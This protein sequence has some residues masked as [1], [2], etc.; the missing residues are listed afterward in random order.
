M[1][2]ALGS[3]TCLVHNVANLKTALKIEDFVKTYAFKELH[4]S[5]PVS[6]AY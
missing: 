1:E 6:I 4:S 2:Q 5:L 3:E